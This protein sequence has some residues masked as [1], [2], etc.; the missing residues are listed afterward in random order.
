MEIVPPKK[1]KRKVLLKRMSPIANKRTRTAKPQPKKGEKNKNK[2]DVKVS[3]Y[4][5]F[6]IQ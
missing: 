4:Y 2:K 3:N 6:V 5:F 1:R